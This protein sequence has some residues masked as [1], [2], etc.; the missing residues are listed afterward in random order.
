MPKTDQNGQS[1]A[2]EE[3][4]VTRPMQLSQV[5]QVKEMQA[6]NSPM[7]IKTYFSSC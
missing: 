7:K 1:H 4:G 6:L 2:E 3:Q 5:S